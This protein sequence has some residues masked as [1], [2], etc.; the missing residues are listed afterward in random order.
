MNHW[1]LATGGPAIVLALLLLSGCSSGK[2][3]WV[4]ASVSGYNH[5]SAAI[6]H[7]S[8]GP[9]LGPAGGPNIGP[10][11]GGGKQSCC[12]VLPRQWYPMRV[13]V[14]WEKDP[15]VGDSANWPERMFSDAW[16]KRMEQHRAKYTQHRAYVD[17]PPY[18][19]EFGPIQIHFLPCDQVRI[20]TSLLTPYHP[21]YPDKEFFNF[22]EPA[23]CHSS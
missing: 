22:K 4:P 1:R 19:E 14:E 21:K 11:Q 17:V 8:V 2:S 10:H 16:H 5:T 9:P 3:K 12:G 23:T 6:N 7:F 20:S 18:G 15:N 13:L